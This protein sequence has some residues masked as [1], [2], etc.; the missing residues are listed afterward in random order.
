MPPLVL[1]IFGTIEM[2][3]MAKNSQSLQHVAREAARVAIIGAPLSSIQTKMEE[4]AP[5]LDTSRV[6]STFEY[7][8]WN[9]TTGAWGAWTTLTDDG[10]ANIASRGDQIRVRLVYSYE[11]AAGGII[12]GVINASDGNVV[13][14]NATMVATRE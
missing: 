10:T 7:R 12:G 4:T 9:E 11:L 13:E 1:L 2:G 5:G 6:S 14:I 8:A 3:L